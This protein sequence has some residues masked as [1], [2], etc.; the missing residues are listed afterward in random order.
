MEEHVMITY[1]K[2]IRGY[3][4]I[5]NW[6]PNCWI[7]VECPTDEEIALLSARF[8]IPQEF[9]TDIADVDERPRTEVDDDWQYLII[10]VPHSSDNSAPF[11]T[12]PLGII[13][14]NDV[15]L[16][17]CY[18]QTQ[19]L[20]DFI[21]HSQRKNI[22]VQNN[23]DFVMRLILSS[24][25]WFLKYLKQINNLI[26]EAERELERSIKN[27][28]LQ[29]LMKIEKSLV[30]FITSLRGNGI[31]F[32][33]IKNLKFSKD[34]FDE[35]LYEDADI[36][37]RQAIETANI[38]SDILGSM[39][40]NYASV[41]SNNINVVMKQLTAVNII[42]MIPTLI[43]SI[44]GMNLTNHLEGISQSF[45]WV[46]TGSFVISIVSVLLF[47]RRDWF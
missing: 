26:Y 18:Y 11:I 36:E 16:T 31:L 5:E 24:S 1:L 33:R 29:S 20:S 2:N 25:V 10:R 40:D 7:N 34:F 46:I 23:F 14:A 27:E 41:I 15:I 44:F 30:Y 45:L 22:N 3:R 13:F 42:L 17:L 43:A 6:E 21:S 39:M 28:E 35:D 19:M 47:K 8:N 38:Q 32:S 9:I 12:A 4:T 37:L